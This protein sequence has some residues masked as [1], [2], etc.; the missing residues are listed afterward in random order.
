MVPDIGYAVMN[1]VTD[2]LT[3][4]GPDTNVATD[5]NFP[6]FGRSITGYANSIARH[7]CEQAMEC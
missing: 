4:M 6:G 1:H 3:T 5:T 2:Y 7:T